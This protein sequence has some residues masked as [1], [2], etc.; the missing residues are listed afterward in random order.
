MGDESILKRFRTRRVLTV[1]ELAGFLGNSTITARRRLKQWNTYTSIN[2]NGRYYVL[3]DVPEFD[4]NGLWNH[5]TI[6]F[7]KRNCACPMLKI[8]WI[9]IAEQVGDCGVQSIFATIT[10]F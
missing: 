7:S 3:P 6:F 10:G 8:I 1:E 4:D 5:K 2:R 9:L